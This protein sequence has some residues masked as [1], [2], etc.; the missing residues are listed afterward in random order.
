MCN[1]YIYIHMLFYGYYMLL[2]M[3][4]LC[5]LDVSGWGPYLHIII[6][7]FK[8]GRLVDDCYYSNQYEQTCYID[9]L[10]VLLLYYHN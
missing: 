2:Y 4:P 1:I 9:W 8:Y 6:C 3:L 5:V 7:G 10:V